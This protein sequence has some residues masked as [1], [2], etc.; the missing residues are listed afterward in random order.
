MMKK[1]FEEFWAEIEAR[2][3]EIAEEE[4]A[5]GR[6]L[7]RELERGRVKSQIPSKGD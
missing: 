3:R 7:R 5:A 2:G 4:Y 1:T 6:G